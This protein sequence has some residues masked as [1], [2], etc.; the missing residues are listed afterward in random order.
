NLCQSIKEGMV[1]FKLVGKILFNMAL[2][3]VFT[4]FGNAFARDSCR[5]HRKIFKYLCECVL[6]ESTITPKR[7]KRFTYHARE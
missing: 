3:E 2:K 5:R 7:K 1:R 4:K 6:F